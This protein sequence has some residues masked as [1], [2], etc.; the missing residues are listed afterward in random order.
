MS[1]E[2]VGA[3]VHQFFKIKV[4]Y[5]ASAS[6]V[7]EAA[8]SVPA[9]DTGGAVLSTPAAEA[10]HGEPSEHPHEHDHEGLS[11]RLALEARVRDEADLRIRLK[12]KASYG[13]EGSHEAAHDAV[14]EFK[15]KIE[16][17]LDLQAS[18]GT[19]SAEGGAAVADARESFGSAVTRLLAAFGEPSGDLGGGLIPGLHAVFGQ[20]V[21]SLAR[22]FG[23]PLGEP[24]ETPVSPEPT[25]SPV[26]SEAEFLAAAFG[27]PEPTAVSAVEAELEVESGPAPSAEEVSQPSLLDTFRA[28]IAELRSIFEETLDELETLR[29]DAQLRARMELR[30]EDVETHRRLVARYDL[31]LHASLMQ[32]AAADPEPAVDLIA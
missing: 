4:D 23:A 19:L 13:S 17:K 9:G 24:A 3:S 32:G 8:A 31:H 15:L 26:A 7:P 6:Q 28:F 27:T 16:A 18:P 30:E 1:I 21:S 11:A 2:S 10:G 29:G 25:A 5:R 20:L 22:A 12:L 14:S